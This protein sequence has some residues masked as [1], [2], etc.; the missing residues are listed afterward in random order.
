MLKKKERCF[1]VGKT[2]TTEY[3]NC[4]RIFC[5]A[6]IIAALLFLPFIIY[7]NGMFLFY[8]D[9]N[10]QQIPFYQVAHDAIRNGNFGWNWN[11]DL[12]SNLI[13]HWSGGIGGE[14]AERVVC[15]FC[16]CKFDY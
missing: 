3:K 8:G 7:D 11:T 2:H 12:G 15:A 6:A 14:P 4:L 1:L 5:I 13:A 9:Y 10:A 16:C